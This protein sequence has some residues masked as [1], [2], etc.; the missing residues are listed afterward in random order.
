MGDP[1]HL[2]T[3]WS[4]SMENKNVKPN[5]NFKR[6]TRI[7]CSYSERDWILIEH[8][9]QLMGKKSVLN[10]LISEIKTLEALNES[11]LD[12]GTFIKKEKKQFYP[13]EGSAK[14]L[15]ALS[16][17]LSLAP[18]TIVSRFILNPLLNYKLISK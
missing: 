3:K 4:Y 5:P 1:V 17:K 18:S 2:N 6:R 12:C 10:Y 7:V 11:L 13:P 16:K 14:I 8:M 9:I 15:S